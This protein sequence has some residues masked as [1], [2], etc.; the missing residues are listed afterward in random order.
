[1]RNF[2]KKLANENVRIFSRNVAFAA[3]PTVKWI[4]LKARKD[5]ER[6]SLHKKI[7]NKFL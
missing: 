1:M 6:R 4:Y 2:A 3:N 5:Y 7:E